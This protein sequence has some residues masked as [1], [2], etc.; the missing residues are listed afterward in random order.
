M[1]YMLAYIHV[2]RGLL[3]SYFDS[4]HLA[5]YGGKASVIVE[6]VVSYLPDLNN[7]YSKIYQIKQ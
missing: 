1:Y 7:F 4:A 5:N 3:E 2:H 6:N